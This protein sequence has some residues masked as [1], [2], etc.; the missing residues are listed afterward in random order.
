MK[1]RPKY[2]FQLKYLQETLPSYRMPTNDKKQIYINIQ[3]KYHLEII[4]QFKI[5]RISI[6]IIYFE[7]IKV[8]GWEYICTRTFSRQNVLCQTFRLAS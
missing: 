3:D 5:Y 2:I 1:N 4:T 8:R 6:K 7:S